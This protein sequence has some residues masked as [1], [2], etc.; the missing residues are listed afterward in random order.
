MATSTSLVTLLQFFHSL[1][2]TPVDKNVEVLEEF[3]L[4]VHHVRLEDTCMVNQ[5]AIKRIYVNI[6]SHQEAKEVSWAFFQDHQLEPISYVGWTCTAYAVHTSREVPMVSECLITEI[7]VTLGTD[8]ILAGVPPQGQCWVALSGVLYCT[9]W[10]QKI[11]RV[12][13]FGCI[14]KCLASYSK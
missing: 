3:C 5:N 10:P 7:C 8:F 12:G 11:V 6:P 4:T 9:V 1:P 13:S 14:L 2:V